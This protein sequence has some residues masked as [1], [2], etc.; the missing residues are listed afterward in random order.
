M[1]AEQELTD[2]V[3]ASFADTPDPRLREVMRSLTRHLHA[4]V[5]DVRLTE[6]E[7]R[8]AIAFRTAATSVIARGAGSASTSCWLRPP[9]L[10]FDD[11]EA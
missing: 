2:R 7:W 3:V 9:T 11:R 5:R 4:F 10:R 6:D 8:A 1:D